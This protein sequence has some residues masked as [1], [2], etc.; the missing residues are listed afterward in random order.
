MRR[1]QPHRP[2]V[3]LP[4]APIAG[5]AHI[6]PTSPVYLPYISHVSPIHLPVSPLHL[7]HTSQRPR[8][9]KPASDG[10]AAN[11]NPN[12]NPNQ[13]KPASDGIAAASGLLRVRDRLLSV[14]GVA[15]LGHAR[16]TAI[17]KA[18]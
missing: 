11:P 8:Q 5:Q 13:A 7:P 6:S 12:P 14:N 1:S 17:L 16:T 3:H 10:I 4:A 18:C 2:P 9:A 15:A